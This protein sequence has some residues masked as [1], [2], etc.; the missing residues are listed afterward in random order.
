MFR[1]RN[2]AISKSS[3]LLSIWGSRPSFYG[4]LPRKNLKTL[5]YRT[6]GAPGDANEKG[7]PGQSLGIRSFMYSFNKYHEHNKLLSRHSM[8]NNHDR[9]QNH[10]KQNCKNKTTQ[11]LCTQAKANEPTVPSRSLGTTFFKAQCPPYST[12]AI[13]VHRKRTKSRLKTKRKSLLF[14]FSTLRK[15]KKRNI[16]ELWE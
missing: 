9:K 12:Q 11:V 8:N 10:E 5:C 4:F 2:N 16:L 3:P 6:V 13:G 7:L 15:K 14:S 1:R